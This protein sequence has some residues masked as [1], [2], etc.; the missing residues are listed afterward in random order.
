[1]LKPGRSSNF[2]KILDNPVHMAY[3]VLVKR[4]RIA[5]LWMIIENNCRLT[6]PIKNQMDIAISCEKTTGLS[7]LKLG[8]GHPRNT[9]YSD[10]FKLFGH[11]NRSN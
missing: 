4:K 2:N 11:T 9:V 3:T 6:W 10:C 5:E 7:K 8:N 1:M